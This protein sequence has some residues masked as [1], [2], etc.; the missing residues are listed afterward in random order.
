[1][2]LVPASEGKTTLA[3]RRASSGRY[4][5]CPHPTPGC[6]VGTGSRQPSRRP[7]ARCS[8]A[9][10][11]TLMHPGC[12]KCQSKGWAPGGGGGETTAPLRSGVQTLGL[13]GARPAIPWEGGGYGSA[14]AHLPVAESWSCVRAQGAGHTGSRW[15]PSVCP[16][17]GPCTAPPRP[18]GRQR[19]CPD[20]HA[21]SQ[22]GWAR[23]A[24]NGGCA[25]TAAGSGCQGEKDPPHP[26]QLS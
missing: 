9:E 1:M 11:Q 6:A 26:R 21:F 14:R 10:V 25:A 20:P 8:Q 5:P 16:H 24:W 18:V 22:G 4:L 12:Q 17:G 19:A 3:P 23:G 2:H 7:Q 15:G 13:L